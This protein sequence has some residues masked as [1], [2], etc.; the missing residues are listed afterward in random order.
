MQGSI[1]A[2]QTPS[3]WGVS[4]TEPALEVYADEAFDTS[5]GKRVLPGSVLRG[6]FRHRVIGSVV[7]DSMLLPPVTGIYSTEDSLT[8]QLAT[9]SAYVRVA[10]REPIPWLLRFRIPPVHNIDPPSW[11]WT[12]LG[13]HNRG[14][15][16]R[17]TNE[18]Y[19][20]QQTEDIFQALLRENQ[21]SGIAVLIDG[22]VEVPHG[23]ITFNSRI[24]VTSMDENVTG[25]PRAALQD[26]IEHT[27]FV[28]RS[29]NP[30]DNGVVSWL[31]IK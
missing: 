1:D 30:G 18:V 31:V 8:N 4:D 19:T 2:M 3:I 5:D 7:D 17:R 23:S 14:I 25:T 27:S 9:Y 28:I 24:I 16:G 13:I 29:N 22:E 11:S 20:K 10:N 26:I 6:D 12:G 15:I 21:L